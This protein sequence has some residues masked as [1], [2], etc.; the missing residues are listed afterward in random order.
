MAGVEAASAAPTQA[1]GA[2]AKR[3]KRKGLP[4]CV[5]DD[6]GGLVAA[7]V[8]LVQR[9]GALA[10]LV[11]HRWPGNVR[12]LENAISSACITATSETIDVE[13]LPES[14][15]QPAGQRGA[16]DGWRPL[17]L[18]EVR[19]EHIERVLQTC[20]GNRLR[21][22]QVLGIGRTSLYRFLKRRHGK[23]S[24]GDMSRRHTAKGGSGKMP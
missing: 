13:D 4:V 12:E 16:E 24:E 5:L 14:L 7:T 23:A 18:E 19:R 6:D 21:A 3:V 9:M 10:R 15:R 8:E 1:P 17:T 11:R 22:A 2:S 20:Q